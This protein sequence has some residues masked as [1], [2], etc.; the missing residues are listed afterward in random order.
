MTINTVGPRF[1]VW[2]LVTGVWASAH[3]PEEPF[4]ASWERVKHQIL[5]AEEQ[6]Y[7]ATLIA[8]HTIHPHGDELDYLEAWAAAAGLA[9]LTSRIEIITAIKPYLSH[10]AMLA[11]QALGVEEISNGRFSLNVV[12]GWFKPEAERTGLPFLDHA[13]RYAYGTEWLTV[14][15][16]LLSGEK[17]S[18]DGA[19]FQIKDLQLFPQSRVRSRP[20][21]YVGGESDPAR[22]LVAGLADVYFIN[23]QP[24]ADVRSIIA[25]VRKRRS[26]GVPLR[27]GL[28]AFVI[29]RSTEAEAQDELARA[30]EIAKAD[31]PERAELAKK[32]DPKVTMFQT[33][34]KNPHIGT[35]GG[36]AAGLVGS[37]EQVVE[38][39][40]AF[41]DLGI[42]LFMLQFQ[43]F[44]REQ[45]RFAEEIIPRVRSFY[46]ERKKASA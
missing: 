8:Q 32:V 43:P 34:A 3:H 36:T 41:H 26:T 6:G 39:I 5:D 40:L 15:R 10:P 4:D 19:Y 22:D 16:K 18:F 21:I 42:E 2:A 11:K 30:W 20:T 33:F 12:N 28:S 17:V 46:G 35:N 38:R 9:S 27:F 7:D 37:Y 29:A 1:G 23:G 31:A 44:E 25:D 45:R 13:E 24:L 14:V